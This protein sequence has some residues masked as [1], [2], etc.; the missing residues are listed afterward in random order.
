MEYV[1]SLFTG[2]LTGYGLIIAIGAQNTYVLT[3]GLKKQFR[4][5]VVLTCSSIDALLIVI[6]LMGMG[7]LVQKSEAI[8]NLIT[9]A[10]IL[11]LTL[12]GAKAFLNAFKGEYLDTSRSTQP[13]VANRKDVLFTTL[14][15]SLLNPHVYLDTVILL[16][17]IGGRLPVEL[18]VAF[19]LGAVIAS[20]SWFFVLGIGSQLVAPWF[21]K[22]GAWKLLDL[23]VGSVMWSIAAT[24]YIHL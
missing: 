17:S 2:L 20:F 3:Q 6:G 5:Q 15:L 8:L 12:Y 4:W 21:K 10:G 23:L 13:T 11:F 16:G 24:L 22:P 7:A 14:A 19:G 1:S 9:W 18:R